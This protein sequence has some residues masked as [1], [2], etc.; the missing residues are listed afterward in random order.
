MD[1][2]YSLDHS[3][4]DFHF[5]QSPRDFVV[6]EIPL[7]EFS[8]EGEHLIL[9]VRKKNLT[10]SELVGI[11]ARYLGIKNRDIG[12]AGLKD[13][14]AMTKQ[15]IS[16]HKQ[17]EEK[18]E[19]FTHESVKIIS[20]TNH[21][22]KIR[23]GHLKGNRFFIKVKKVNPT[24]AIKIDEALKNIANFGMPNFFGFQRFG[25]DGDNHIIGEKIAKGEARERNPRVKKLLINA[26][27]SHLFNLWLSRRLEINRLIN[28]FEASELESV[29]NMP[30]DEVSKLKLQK[31]PFKLITG[32]IMEHY[33]HGRL[34]DFEGSKEDLS[35]F[36]EK[37]ISVTGLLCGKKAKIVSGTARDIEK[38]FDETINADGTRRYA[39]VFPE[40]IE[41]RFKQ[42]EAQYEMNFTLPKGSYATVLIEEI[43]KRK[44]N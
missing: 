18:L 16:V 27:Q 40:D 23:I 17:H 33:P 26:Y 6:E 28:N 12:Y 29:L 24:S 10:T 9:F 21:N 2:F 43:A 25:N 42:E 8:G 22:N 44:I 32:D 34:F 4:I 13:K 35:R 1:R 20:K 38:D 30:N 36:N 41:G 5:K 39:W 7:Y 31:H 3:S 14:H 19:S 15:Y 37:D 11:F